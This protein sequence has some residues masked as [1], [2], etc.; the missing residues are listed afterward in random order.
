MKKPRCIHCQETFTPWYCDSGPTGMATHCLLCLENPAREGDPRYVIDGV[1]H[2][3]TDELD[4][5]LDRLPPSEW[6]PHASRWT[7]HPP[8]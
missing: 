4:A 5:K 1:R 6:S 8:G 2:L 7:P 3:P